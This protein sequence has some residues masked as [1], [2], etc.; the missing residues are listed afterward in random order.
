MEHNQ[1]TNFLGKK[2]E[3]L[4]QLEEQKKLNQSLKQEISQTEEESAQVQSQTE[5][6][7]Q[8][9]ARQAFPSLDGLSAQELMFLCQ[10]ATLKYNEQ[11]VI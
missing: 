8:Q 6:L 2:Q 7:K 10:R 4:E 1:N 11:I 9:S 5:G 3:L